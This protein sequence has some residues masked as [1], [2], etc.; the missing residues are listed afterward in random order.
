MPAPALAQPAGPRGD[1][2]RRAMVFLGVALLAVIAVAGGFLVMRDDEKAGAAEVFLEP[3]SSTGANPF[4]SSVAAPAPSSTVRRSTTTTQ[5]STSTSA[6]NRSTTTQARNT[7]TSFGGATPGL[8]GGT[9]NNSSCDVE[10][11]VGFLQANPAK[12]QAWASVFGGKPADIPAFVRTL[13]PLLL[14]RDTRVTNH[15]FRNG[16]ANAFQAVLQAGT[17][18]LVDQFGVPRVKCGCGNPLAPPVPLSSTPRYTGPA[19]PEFSP[20]N[21]IVVQ[22]TVKVNVFVVNDV[23]NGGTFTRPPGTDGAADE[24]ISADSLCDLYPEHPDCAGLPP[25]PTTTTTRPGEPTLGT[26]DV[27]VTLR[28]D[29]TADLDLGVTDPTGATI[30]FDNPQSPSGG[31]LDV[32]SNGG[33]EGATSTPV[34]NVFWPEGASPDGDYIVTVSYYGECAGGGSGPQTFTLD[35]KL[36]GVSVEAQEAAT[37][38]RTGSLQLESRMQKSGTLQPG[39]SKSYKFSKTQGGVTTTVQ[40]EPETTTTE[41]TTTTL[42]CAERYPDDFMMQTLCEHDPT[43]ND[44]SN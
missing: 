41:A 2:T 29:T 40:P 16:R 21:V 18:V 15:G 43:M 7:V 3:V 12:A 35:V 39:E 31:Q 9:Q 42:S 13:T 25:S 28:W 10:Q 6:S 24:P 23:E 8:Y 34:E 26:G 27:Q 36:G 5:R 4:T 32:D 22:Q 19:W 14:D 33:C 20:T 17:A 37:Q 38:G 30:Y 1:S 11:L 44:V